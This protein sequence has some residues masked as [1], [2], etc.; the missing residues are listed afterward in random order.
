MKKFRDYLDER[1]EVNKQLTNDVNELGTAM[2]SQNKEEVKEQ[3]GKTQDTL[4]K[5]KGYYN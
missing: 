4:D 2:K 3:L 1:S 5:L